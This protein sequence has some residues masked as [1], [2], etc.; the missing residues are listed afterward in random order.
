[1]KDRLSFLHHL[2]IINKGVHNSTFSPE[3]IT[4]DAVAGSSESVK[5][6]GLI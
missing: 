3:S 5:H 1:V 4:A 6:C 2:L